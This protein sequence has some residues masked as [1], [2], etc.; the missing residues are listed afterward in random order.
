MQKGEKMAN[1]SVIGAGAFGTSLAIYSNRI[2][3]NV[4]VW[5]FEKDL[6]GIVSEKGENEPY[7]PG[8]EIDQK[9]IFS[10]D[11]DVVLEDA[12]YCLMVCPSSFMRM[13]A[14]GV[15]KHISG[16]TTIISATKGIENETLALMSDILE[17]VFPDKADNIVYMSGPSFAKEIAIGLPADNACASKNIE[18][19]RKFQE[20]FHS[21]K[22]RLYTS[23]DIIGI[24]LGGSLKN[25]IAVACGACDELGLGLSARASLITR[26]LAEIN[27]LAVAMGAHPITLSGLTGVGDLI[28]T[29]TG[30]LSRNRTLGKKLARGMKASEIISSQ[31]AVAEGY[32]TAKSVFNLSKK[33]NVEMPISEAVYRVC[34]EDA[35]IKAE[36]MKLMKRDKKDEFNGLK[37]DSE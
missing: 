32:V 1:I 28:L 6:P 25:V 16:K 13:T 4:K 3:H 12:D 34:Y 10:N 26:G 37:K 30:D 24:E 15:K 22:F 20:D 33:M 18:V 36:A 27:R 9:I 21:D 23:D 2:G 35:D 19:A 14:K 17:E 29:C 31:K 7:L 11:F 5:T 8:F